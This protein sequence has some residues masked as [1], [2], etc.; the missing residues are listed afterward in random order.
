MG[1]PSD[2]FRIGGDAVGKQENP[3]QWS[4]SKAI[5]QT[6]QNAEQIGLRTLKLEPGK[7]GHPLQSRL[8]NISSDIKV[9]CE[10]HLPGSLFGG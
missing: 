9:L 6:V 1:N 8:K 2:L 4:I 3:R 7:I 5:L 10:S